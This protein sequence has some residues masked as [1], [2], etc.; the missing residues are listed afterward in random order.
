MQFAIIAIKQPT[1]AI[2]TQIHTS[3]DPYLALKKLT[4]YINNINTSSHK[5]STEVLIK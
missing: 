2:T 5:T 4:H 3:I 1:I